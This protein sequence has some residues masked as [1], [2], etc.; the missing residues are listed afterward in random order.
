[1]SMED[2]PEEAPPMCRRKIQEV[3][4]GVDHRWAAVY[5]AV[6][7]RMLDYL[8]QCAGLKVGTQKAGIL[9]ASAK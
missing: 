9:R 7:K 2:T 6:A 5:Q 4:C 1:M 3:D 8:N